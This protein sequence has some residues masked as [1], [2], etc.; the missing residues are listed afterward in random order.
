MPKR[1]AFQRLNHSVILIANRISD[2]RSVRIRH[3]VI[4]PDD[5]KRS[6]SKPVAFT[7]RFIDIR[8]HICFDN[9]V[10]FIQYKSYKA[11]CDWTKE[12]SEE[13]KETFEAEW[14]WECGVFVFILDLEKY[15]NH[16]QPHNAILHIWLRF[17][18]LY[19]C[20]LYA[21]QIIPS[22]AK[23]RKITSKT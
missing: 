18:L 17:L 13:K 23:T 11:F 15:T 7:I 5:L 1:V 4:K 12:S 20:N 22:H 8:K 2:W 21:R 10:F 3:L 19:M 6:H 14:K 16:W 9:L